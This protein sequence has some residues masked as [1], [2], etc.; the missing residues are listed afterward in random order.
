M[1][2]ERKEILPPEGVCTSEQGICPD[3]P[4]LLI[5]KSQKNGKGV[6]ATRSFVQGEVVL[7]GVPR[8]FLRQPTRYS[9]QVGLQE[10]VLFDELFSLINHSCAPTTFTRFNS[11]GGYDF[12]ARYPLIAGEEITFDYETTEEWLC[13]PIEP[14]QCGVATCRQSI[15]GFRFFPPEMQQKHYKTGFCASYLQEAW[16][17]R[18]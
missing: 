12:V 15:R 2:Q 14:C 18:E 16:L 11:L 5:G 4:D 10:H 6:F 7:C 3:Y 1:K 13:C 8:I 9:Y 17:Q